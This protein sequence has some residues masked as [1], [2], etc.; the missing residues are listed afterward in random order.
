MITQDSAYIGR[1]HQ[2]FVLLPSIQWR[3]HCPPLQY[4]QYRYPP[5]NQ[6]PLVDSTRSISILNITK[7]AMKF[8]KRLESEAERRW[9]EHYIDYKALKK[10]IKRDVELED[11]NSA[12]F[13]R[14]LQFELNKVSSFY[15]SQESA[16]ERHMESCVADGMIPEGC[17]KD[18]KV[19]SESSVVDAWKN[20]FLGLKKEIHDLN[21]F[22]MLNYIAVVKAVKKRNRH[23][24]AACPQGMSSMRAGQILV[25]Q[26]FCSSL[27]LAAMST[28][29]EIV[30]H[31]VGMD[32]E[33]LG[34]SVE[35]EYA[36]PICLNMLNNPVVLSCAHR[37]CWGC[38]VSL[39][40]SV[41]RDLANGHTEDFDHKVKGDQL[42]VESA[43]STSPDST[44]LRTAVWESDL[45]DDENSTV[46][47]FQCPCCRKQELLNLERLHV[48]Q[49]LSDYIE[50]LG[51]KG[52]MFVGIFLCGF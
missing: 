39:C 16:V 24:K 47:T 18:S 36:C 44:V 28:R 49:H 1:L 29:V 3:L 20:E 38:I 45:S 33:L 37:Y 9:L 50:T 15:F 5:L 41:K 51:K 52:M 14:V 21:K 11:P 23:M 35:E 17:L 40:S 46:A 4:H 32:S 31:K 42:M 7:I 26:Y 30:S 10:S 2:D 8:G 27:K 22:V 12:E 43:L 48:D 19:A 6:Y 34:N 13:R 25:G